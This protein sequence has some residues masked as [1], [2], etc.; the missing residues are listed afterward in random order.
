VRMLAVGE[1]SIKHRLL[2]AYTQKLQYILPEHVPSE[3][4]ELLV[5]IRTRLYRRPRYEGQS[6]VESALY[7]MHNSKATSIASDI[8]EL[9]RSLRCSRVA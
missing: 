6:T 7:R 9:A 3:M 4:S 1:H 2:L 8:V 5:S